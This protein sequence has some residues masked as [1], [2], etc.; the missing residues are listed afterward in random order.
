MRVEVEGLSRCFGRVRALADVSF[1]LPTGRRVALVGPNGSGKS[2]LNRVLVGLLAFEGRVRIDGH[3][4]RDHRPELASRIA[5]LP[6]VSPQ[7]AAPVRELVRAVASLRGIPTEAVRTRARQLDLDL[8][9]VATRPLRGLSGGM[10]RKLLLALTLASP[11]SFFVLD[12]PTGSL[13]PMAR[14]RFYEVFR[15]VGEG[16]TLLLCSHRLEE[17]KSLVDHVMVLEEGRIVRDGPVPA[18]SEEG[19]GRIFDFPVEAQR[20]RGRGA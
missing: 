2:T 10:R 20:A 3:S 14:Q 13:D 6:Q 17:V 15:R 12:E 1:T 4:P 16:A 5:Y 9:A 19:G 18:R 7:L 8:E 11:A